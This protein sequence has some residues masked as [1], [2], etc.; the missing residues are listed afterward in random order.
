[1]IQDARR[2]RLLWLT[3]ACATFAACGGGGGGA[4]GSTPPPPPPPPPASESAYLLAEF[5]AGDSN[6]Q[7][8]RVWDPARPAVAVQ[9]I[10]L[11]MSNGIIWTSSHLVFSD[12]T[13]YDASSRKVTTLG[14]AKVFFDNDGKLYGIDLRGGQSHAP[15]RLSNAV[16]VFQ[17]RS[18]IAMNAAGDDAW[19]DAQGGTNDWAVRTSMSASTAPVLV[20]RILA[21]LRDAATGLPQYLFASVAQQVG[22]ALGP[23][24]FEVVDPSFTVV[25]DA[26]VST[27]A[28]GDMWL[29]PDPAQA[30]TGYVVIAN[31]LR[32]MHWSAGG[33]TVDAGGLYSFAYGTVLGLSTAADD[34]SLYVSDGGGGVVA[35]TNGAVRTVGTLSG[36]AQTI[37]DAGDY[38]AAV[39][40]SG[41]TATQTSYQLETLRKSDG[42]LTLVEPSSSTL[43]LM[44]ASSQGLVIAGSAAQPQAFVLASG[45]NAT[46]TTVGTQPVGVVVS[47]S[48]PLDRPAAPVALLSCVS[49]AAVGACAP[50]ALMQLDFGGNA[51]AA[52]GPLAASAPRVRGDAV[53]GLTTSLAGQTLL[54]SPAGFGKNQ[55]D[56]RDAWQ[57]TPSTAGSVT[58]VTTNVP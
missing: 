9:N 42:L 50:G 23:V 45:D 35:V 25:P 44:G 57:F 56:K 11:V 49:G 58:R 48:A 39:E 15:V 19:I 40:R 43:E 52:L 36:L 6:N 27:M 30:G 33:V 53:A 17:P 32:K 46:R 29:A 2:L 41:S 21:P 24:T 12:A 4:G 54:S 34:Q 8:V 51:L 18:A 26:T 3:F 7:Y 22:T 16:D 1:M 38:I 37:H 10:R 5:V 28:S 13:R 20:N 47:A 31:E 14:H 55:T